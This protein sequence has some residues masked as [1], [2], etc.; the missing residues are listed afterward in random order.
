[1]FDFIPILKTVIYITVPLAVVFSFAYFGTPL[2]KALPLFFKDTFKKIIGAF[3]REPKPFDMYGVYLYNG[4]G[5]NGKT[6]SMVNKAVE[7][8]RKFPKV[9]IMGNFHANIIDK[10]FDKWEDILNT[11]NIDENGVNQGVLILFDEMHLTLNSQGWRN[12]PDELLEYISLQR[13]FIEKY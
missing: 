10:Y 2:L 9:L 12:A 7:I 6:I 13:H 1:M 4:L 8:K 11:E 5:G 3:K